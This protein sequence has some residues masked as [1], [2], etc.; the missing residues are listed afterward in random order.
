MPRWLSGRT[1]V[2]NLIIDYEDLETRL[3]RAIN[4]LDTERDNLKTE[5]LTVYSQMTDYDAAEGNIAE[6]FY[7]TVEENESRIGTIHVNL[8]GII[9]D[10]GNK[11]TEISRKLDQLASYRQIEVNEEREL[12]ENE[13]NLN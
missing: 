5:C 6:L 8:G 13:I 10:L 12:A 4:T 3:E 1:L 9:S 2:Q 11:K 7:N